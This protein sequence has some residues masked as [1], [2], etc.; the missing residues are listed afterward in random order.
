MYVDSIW[1]LKTFGYNS[2]LQI[3]REKIGWVKQLLKGAAVYDMSRLIPS[4]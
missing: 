2:A 1:E 4:V 3:L